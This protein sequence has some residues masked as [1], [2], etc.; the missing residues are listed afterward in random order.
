MVVNDLGGDVH[1]DGADLTPAQQVVDEI[2]AGG[3]TAMISGHDVADWDA[4]GD[5]VEATVRRF[6]DLHV[7]VNN[8]GILRD[9]TLANLSE[10]EWDA[11]VRVHLKGHAA[12]SRHAAAHWRRQAKAGRVVDA[13]VIHT[14]SASGLIGNFG[15]TN[16]GAAKAGIV[17]LSHV[18]ALEL[19]GIGVRSNVIAPAAATRMQGPSDAVAADDT[20]RMRRVF[21][22]NNVSPLVAWL[23]TS[24]CPAQDQVFHVYGNRV[25][26]LSLR[27]HA[28][29][30]TDTPWTLESLDQVVRPRLAP[31]LRVSDVLSFGGAR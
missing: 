19:G 23:A 10:E 13:S 22:P 2:T 17:G 9:R 21:D 31:P 27:V 11:V 24:E 6:G 26:V 7:L 4:A 25:T 28:D 29:I 5:L 18:M 15:Q 16:Y 3:G 1:G 8:A 30:T 12:M 14:S 20:E